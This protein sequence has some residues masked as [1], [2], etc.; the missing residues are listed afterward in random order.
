MSEKKEEV[1]KIS[2][3]EAFL[4]LVVL[5]V[6]LTLNVRFF[7]DSLA[8]PNQIALLTASAVAGIIGVVRGFSYEMMFG[9]SAR[10]IKAT[11]SA[12]I[13]LMFIGALSG[14]WLISGI[15]PTMIYYGIQILNPQFFLFSTAII[16]A[17]ISLITGSSWS[18]VATMGIALL[19]IG[20]TL[21]FPAAVIG[22]AIISGSY[23]GDKLSPMSDTTNLAAAVAEVDLIKHI[24]YMLL[25]TIPSM[26]VALILYIGLGF[27]YH[28][29]S[30]AIDITAMNQ[31]L[32][33]N[34]NI[35]PWLFLVPVIVIVLIMKK[36][37]ALP[38]L[39]AGTILGV[40]FALI[41]QHE[42][43]LKLSG[44]SEYSFSTL[45]KTIVDS[46]INSVSIETGNKSL[47]GLLSSKGMVGMLNTIWLIVT[48][49]V[50]GGFMEATGSLHRI[51]EL[52]LRMGKGFFSLIFATTGTTLFFNI[53]A[54]DQYLAIVVP[55]RMYADTF[56]ERGYAP[57]NLSRTLEDTGTVTSALIPWNTCGATQA[58]VL[59]VATLAYAPFA[60]FNLISPIMTLIYA[61]FKIKITNIDS[62]EKGEAET[63]VANS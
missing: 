59:G 26:A 15:V 50:F 19:G 53:T 11:G 18:T 55:G 30:E 27:F 49:M 23:F 17:I 56:K 35:T 22:G 57:E 7:D 8:G 58:S 9:Y 60:F 16:T 36:V 5:L 32:E 33:A 42:L 43:L 31:A 63:E 41:F 14:S 24:K 38:A 20:Q 54:A 1:K 44:E 28:S 45:Y 13:I 47:D 6:L 3:F 21:G 46:L 51:S 48:A 52:L 12:L 40:I 39:F 4:P 25:T 62:D 2:L 10:N 61:A 29:K 34:F 37:P